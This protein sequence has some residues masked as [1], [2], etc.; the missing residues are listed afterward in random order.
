MK[1]SWNSQVGVA[2]AL[3]SF[4]LI[5]CSREYLTTAETDVTVTIGGKDG[6]VY[7]GYKTYLLPDS[8]VDLCEAAQDGDDADIG[9]VIGGAGGGPSIDPDECQETNH[10]LDDVILSAL[11]KNMDALGYREI[12]DP[13]QEEPDLAFFAGTIAHDNWYL[14]T[15]PGYCYPSYYYYNC[16]YPSYSYAYNL[17]TQAILIDLADTAKSENGDLHSVWTVILQGLDQVSSEQTG[18][19]RINNAV[20]QAFK[21]SPYLAEGG[22]N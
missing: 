15:S 3:C 19:Q 17:P 18:T 9:E 13:T 4:S 5:S 2:L 7:S 11:R 14:A 12:D 22:A 6:D 20:N 8:V 21:Q 1:A 16:W 10:D